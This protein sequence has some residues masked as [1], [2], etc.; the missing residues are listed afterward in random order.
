MIPDEFDAAQE[1]EEARE[2]DETDVE[3]AWPDGIVDVVTD[4]E[5]VAPDAAPGPVAGPS[6]SAAA[7]DGPLS[8]QDFARL[9]TPPYSV[10]R[11]MFRETQAR[12]ER[13]EREANVRDAAAA[14][15]AREEPECVI[16]RDPLLGAPTVGFQCGH[17]YHADC[18]LGARGCPL[19]GRCALRFLKVETC[20]KCRVRIAAV[21]PMFM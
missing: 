14:K 2:P 12:C 15:R 21:T 10:V 16:C 1:P 13:E 4:D 20:P 9:N 19:L 3:D 8:P 11:L 6:T 5:A 18:M 17:I 7:R